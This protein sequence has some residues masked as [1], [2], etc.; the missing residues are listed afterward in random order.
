LTAEDV[1][2]PNG[3]VEGFERVKRRG[4]VRFAG[5]TAFG[6]DTACIER[7]IDSGAFDSIILSY[8]IL[9][10]SAF[11]DGPAVNPLLTYDRVGARAAQRGMGVFALR[12]LEAGALASGFERHALATAPGAP[13]YATYVEQAQTLRFLAAEGDPTLVAPAI[14]FVLANP[15]VSTALVGISEVSHVDAAADAEERGPLDAAALARI[16]ELRLAGFR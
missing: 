7:M 10:Q 5:C 8:S 1:F 13:A 12:V 4:L 3:V 15:A 2:G 14:R 11:L 6:G 9:N 16:E